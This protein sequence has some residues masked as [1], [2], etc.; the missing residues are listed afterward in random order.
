ME[1]E[2]S[3]HGRAASHVQVRPSSSWCRKSRQAVLTEPSTPTPNSGHLY[4]AKWWTQNENPSSKR[5]SP[6]R[7]SE[8][9]FGMRLLIYSTFGRQHQRCLDRQRG[10]QR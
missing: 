5:K 6:L 9:V 10:L 1:F 3:L 8:G 7:P 2:R 4:T